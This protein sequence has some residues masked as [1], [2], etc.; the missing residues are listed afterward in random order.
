MDARF[1]DLLPDLALF[2]VIAEA[3]SLSAASR[4]TGVPVARLSRRLAALERT[5]GVRLVERTPRRFQ[6]T[7]E[8]EA[9]LASLR[10]VL[11]AVADA[12]GATAEEGREPGGVLRLAASPDFGAVFLAPL[13]AEFAT[14][15][16][17]VTFDIDLSPRRVELGAERFDAAIR[18]GPL[19]DSELTSRRFATVPG[20]L[21]AAP[22]YLEA[23]GR[24][25][26]PSDLADH[27]C[28]PLPHMKEM[29]VLRRGEE[30]CRVAMPGRVKVN[31]LLMLRRLCGEGLGIAALNP[32]IAAEGGAHCPVERVLA[33]WALEPAVF[34]FLTPARL[35]PARTRAF[36]DFA[37]SRL[38]AQGY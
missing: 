30:T 28:L 22:A 29:A 25:R 10:P 20:E 5:V 35:L 9:Y 31:N 12:F 36:F 17:K 19:P 34:Y 26:H 18:I 1:I 8:G 11:G 37:R 16:P 15:H 4:A 21:Y 2:V 13:V 33:D 24:P 38:E 14:L 32:V 7:A 23:H 3:D 27:R 6:L